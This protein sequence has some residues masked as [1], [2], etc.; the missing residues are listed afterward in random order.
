MQ[1]HLNQIGT[2]FFTKINHT[3]S[4]LRHTIFMY[5]SGKTINTVNLYAYL[6]WFII[7][8]LCQSFLGLLYVI[9]YMY[10]SN[11]NTGLGAISL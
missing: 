1:Y 10:I 6:T 9:F 4:N 7:I 8:L 2:L 11:I 3:K 5:L